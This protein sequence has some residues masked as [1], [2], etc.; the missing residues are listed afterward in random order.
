MMHLRSEILV[1]V[2]IWKKK[3]GAVY[4]TF[5]VGVLYLT[6]CVCMHLQTEEFLSKL[7]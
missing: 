6:R 7:A 4:V 5:A 2:E 3:L 1:L